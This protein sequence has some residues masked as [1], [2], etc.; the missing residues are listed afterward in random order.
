MH[1]AQ[2]VTADIA[3]VHFARFVLVKYEQAPAW[4]FL[5]FFCSP[6]LYFTRTCAA[7]VVT[8][9][10]ACSNYF[11]IHHHHYKLS[12]DKYERMNV[13]MEYSQLHCIL[14][15]IIIR[16]SFKLILASFLRAKQFVVVSLLS[17]IRGTRSP[18]QMRITSNHVF[19]LMWNHLWYRF[20]QHVLGRNV[21]RCFSHANGCLSVFG[22][23]CLWKDAV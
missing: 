6:L 5:Y 11:I 1:Y 22:V 19:G 7:A 14:D 20:R 10:S 15:R 8:H 21:A 16:I 9:S 17:K 23:D 18:N 3:R 13:C 4:F 12:S 2:D